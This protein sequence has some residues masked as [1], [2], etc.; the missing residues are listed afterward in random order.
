MRHKILKNR[1]AIICLGLLVSF[2]PYLFLEERFVPDAVHLAG[3]FIF[4][5]DIIIYNSKVCLNDTTDSVNGKKIY[6]ISLALTILFAL[7]LSVIRILTSPLCSVAT[8]SGYFPSF[9][10]F[11]VVLWTYLIFVP[12]TLIALYVFVQ[13]VLR[14]LL[15]L[16]SLSEIMFKNNE[17]A[18]KTE[19]WGCFILVTLLSLAFL[20]STYPGIFLDDDVTTVVQ[21]ALLKLWD[22][23]HTLGYL[24][25]VRLLIFK[26][27]DVFTVNIVQTIIWIFIQFYILHRIKNNRKS[28]FIYTALSLLIFTSCNYLEIMLKDTV[29]AMGMLCMTAVIYNVIV[30]KK[31]TVLDCIAGVIGTLMVSLFRHGGVVIAGMSLVFLFLYCIV[32]N[33]K[34]QKM[35]FSISLLAIS[36]LSYCIINITVS[37]MLNA[38]RNPSYIKYSTPLQMISAAAYDGYEFD[39]E[40][41]TELEKF[42]PMEKWTELYDP[43]WSD[44]IARV[45]GNPDINKLE[46]LIKTSNYG[47]TLIKINAKILI[48]DPFLYLKALAKID[49]II[50]EIS[51][52]L[53][54]KKLTVGSICEAPKQDYIYY[55]GLYVYTSGISRFTNNI[56]IL[57][58]FYWRGGIYLMGAFLAIVCYI[59]RKKSKYII[60]MAPV[61][62]NTGLLLLAC[63]AQ[64]PRYILPIME[65]MIFVFAT[66]PFSLKENDS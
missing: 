37:N 57:I 26:T 62:L 31:V 64:D 63:P 52:P 46:T 30:N 55:S 23:W 40:D 12:I 14:F 2:L 60:V 16:N 4:I 65:T 27:L 6:I 45:W 41:V 3:L 48:H 56:P 35:I 29:Y 21:M 24:L 58:S 1:K 39:N 28:M 11:F 20:F 25:F 15:G 33:E 50:I 5:S 54:A 59:V 19:F 34:Q 17:K 42:M 51:R 13:F 61:L 22:H 7:S 32:K 36:V 49:S 53:D 66:L 44:S 9:I 10:A 38:T 47:S 8:L 18:K 43:Y